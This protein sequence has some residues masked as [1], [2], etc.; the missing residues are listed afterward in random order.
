MYDVLT[1]SRRSRVKVWGGIAR[2]FNNMFEVL[3][4]IVIKKLYLHL[5]ICKN[6]GKELV[7]RHT[8]LDDS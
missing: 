7:K 2:G 4:S 8:E 5:F 6:D 1:N 3:E